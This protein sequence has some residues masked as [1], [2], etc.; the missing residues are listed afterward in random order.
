MKGVYHNSS[1]LITCSTG[2]KFTS[3]QQAGGEDREQNDG[4]EGLFSPRVWVLSAFPSVMSNSA[5]E[6]LHII[7]HL[8]AYKIQSTT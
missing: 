2:L 5:H 8:W 3:S 6:Y 4:K 1:S 7:T